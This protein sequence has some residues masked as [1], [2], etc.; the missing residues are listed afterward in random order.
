MFKHNFSAKHVPV[1]CIMQSKSGLQCYSHRAGKISYTVSMA[2]I[3]ITGGGTGGHIMPNIALIPALRKRFDKI[4]YVGIK[5]GREEKAAKSARIPFLDVPA[6]KLD[7]QKIFA[8]LLIPAR[9]SSCVGKA[10][11]LLRGIEPDVVFCKGGFVSLPCALAA[12][13]LGIPVIT[14]ESDMSPGVANKIISRFAYATVTSYPQTKAK[15][16]VYIGNPIRREIFSAHKPPVKLSASRPTVLIVGGSTGALA[17]NKA[18]WENLDKLCTRYNVLHITGCDDNPKHANYYPVKY[19]D[20]IFD[21]YD[22][23]DAVVSRCG[24]NA[25]CELLAMRKKVVFVPLN[26]RA[27]RGDQVEN[28]RHYVNMECA[29]MCDEKQLACDAVRIIDKA[30]SMPMPRYTYDV[31]TDEKIAALCLKAAEE[32]KRAKNTRLR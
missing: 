32:G 23:A 14:H 11:E 26:N 18:V 5:G 19:A 16:A 30:L 7:R 10:K 1:V 12:H 13:K 31:N 22:C 17:L 2:T 20:N 24:A 29:A 25:A 8:N 21:Y 28:A 4:Y 15:N 3:V 6:V 27:S 9:L